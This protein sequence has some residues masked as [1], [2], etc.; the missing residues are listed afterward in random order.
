[1]AER[2]DRPESKEVDVIP[3]TAFMIRKKIYEEMKGFDEKF[4]LYF[5]EYDLCKTC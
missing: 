2:M 5:E 1:M 4:F 3:G